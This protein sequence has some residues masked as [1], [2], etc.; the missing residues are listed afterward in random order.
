MTKYENL[1]SIL[2]QVRFESPMEFKSYRPKQDDLEKINQARG[3]AL[4][5]LYLMQAQEQHKVLL[6]LIH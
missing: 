3:R 4:I 6:R 2:D 1:V 5:H